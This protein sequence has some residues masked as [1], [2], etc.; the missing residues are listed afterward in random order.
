ME[1]IT[2][3]IKKH[4]DKVT[5]PKQATSGSVGFDL[6]VFFEEIEKYKFIGTDKR[7]DGTE[8][9]YTMISPN[10]KILFSTELSFEIPE[11]YYMQ[12]HPR[13]SIGIKKNLIISNLIPVIDADYRGKVYLSFRNI[14]DV[15]IRVEE[16]ERLAQGIILPYPKVVFEE[17]EELSET[18]R[19]GGIGSSGTI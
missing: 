2:V 19:K 14:G 13:S 6:S 4:N 5:I 12:I 15:A 7:E 9:R 3:K 18:D 1:P 8:Y 16:G 11:G 17:V 10:E